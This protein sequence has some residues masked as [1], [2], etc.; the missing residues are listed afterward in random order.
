MDTL[1]V[2]RKI[3][4]LIESLKQKDTILGANLEIIWSQIDHQVCGLLSFHAHVFF[5]WTIEG[6]L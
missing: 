4:A 6:N 2:W 5:L 3:T 1:E